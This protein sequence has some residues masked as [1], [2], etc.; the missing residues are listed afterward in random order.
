VKE[1]LSRKQ[2]SL[3]VNLLSHSSVEDA[4]AASG[5]SRSTVYRWMQ[6]DA[7]FRRAFSDAKV[8][9]FSQ[10]ITIL[11]RAATTFAQTLEQIA[12]DATA[13]MTAR[14]SAC[15]AGLEWAT[16]GVDSE[17]TAADARLLAQELHQR[18]AKKS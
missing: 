4:A 9:A 8:A 1:Q 3:I 18:K 11:S 6:D 10:A 16:R 2:L 7:A 12:M 17:S 13:P 15:R 5:V 14:V